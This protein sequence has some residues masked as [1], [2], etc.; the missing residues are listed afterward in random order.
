M[1]LATHQA[2]SL[3]AVIG[4][5]FGGLLATPILKLLVFQ[6][7]MT[8]LPGARSRSGSIPISTA[9]PLRGHHYRR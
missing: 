4:I 5:F 8:P 6:A 3:V 9:S 2:A 1:G 7:I